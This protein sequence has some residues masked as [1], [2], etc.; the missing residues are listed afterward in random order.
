MLVGP[1]LGRNNRVQASACPQVWAETTQDRS[2]SPVLEA[3][4]M[5]YSQGRP[6]GD[7]SA[8]SHRS[9]R[10]LAQALM[11]CSWGS[12]SGCF[13]VGLQPATIVIVKPN[14]KEV[15]RLWLM[16]V[17]YLVRPFAGREKPGRPARWAAPL[18]SIRNSRAST[19]RS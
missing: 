7:G 2:T 1:L 14:S 12:G 15:N 8:D 4:V 16:S 6:S 19:F 11:A 17:T 5:K 18:L 10:R 9:L 3:S 13:G